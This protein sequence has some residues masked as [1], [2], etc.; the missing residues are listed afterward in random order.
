LEYIDEEDVTAG[1]VRILT[2]TE[3]I[4][5][6][7]ERPLQPD[8]DDIQLIPRS[9]SRKSSSMPLV[10][11]GLDRRIETF[12]PVQMQR[13]AKQVFEE[14]QAGS[15]FRSVDMLRAYQSSGKDVLQVWVK[16]ASVIV[17]VP[18][19]NTSW[20]EAKLRTLADDIAFQTQAIVLL[21][22]IHRLKHPRNENKQSEALT[23]DFESDETAY[24]RVFD[25]LMA[26]VFHSHKQLKARAIAF[27]GLGLGADI[28]MRVAAD[29]HSLACLALVQEV[30]GQL[31][32]LDDTVSPGGG[33][34]S[35]PAKK[36]VKE[37]TPI[38]F[39][40]PPDRVLDLRP[41]NSSKKQAERAALMELDD[42]A[43]AEMEEELK[44]FLQSLDRG[45]SDITEVEESDDDNDSD[46]E[47]GN[48]E[49]DKD[50]GEEGVTRDWVRII[51]GA[52]HAR[53]QK[54]L[55]DY[56]SI[57]IREL[58]QVQPRAVAAL[59]PQRL[60]HPSIAQQL[61]SALYLVTSSAQKEIVERAKELK[62]QLDTRQ[63]ELLDYSFRVYEGRSKEFLYVQKDDLDA[64]CAQDAIDIASLWM[65]ALTIPD[66]ND[67]VDG[68]GTAK[69]SSDAW[70]EVRMRDM[71]LPLRSST[72]AAYLHE[73]PD[74]LP[75]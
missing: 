7:K 12:P 18:P 2:E 24:R 74:F 20:G 22:D 69:M 65:D 52:R 36:L 25:D 63:S 46:G 1:K 40:K 38:L 17:F 58:L 37:F 16:R 64:K 9:S 44:Q 70:M 72:V 15:K 54:L 67:L 57:P 39:R 34:W 43:K 23:T 60:Q 68:A 55:V 41:T 71:I 14:D 51:E 13:T 47:E 53:N 75:K 62:K 50:G 4:E 27:A 29:M 3:R 33:L 31:G 66:D 48:V 21:P 73:V 30:E 32:V 11:D 45:D 28:A 59:Q 10:M 56:P 42:E 35:E 6:S 19:F 8:S 61:C 5:A 26:T 49:Q